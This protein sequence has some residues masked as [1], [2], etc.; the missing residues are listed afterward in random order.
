MR[1]FI[2]PSRNAEARPPPPGPTHRV[3]RVA[4]AARKWARWGRTLELKGTVG[5]FGRDCS[6]AARPGIGVFY[7]LLSS[8]LPVRPVGVEGVGGSIQRSD[9]QVVQ[10]QLIVE[11]IRILYKI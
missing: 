8:V 11:R 5:S 1:T 9:S 6:K 10:V 2:R 4:A 7:K 3:T